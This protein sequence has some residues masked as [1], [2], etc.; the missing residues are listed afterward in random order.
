MD[1]AQIIN[2]PEL[3]QIVIIDDIGTASHHQLGFVD[4]Y[5]A[6]EEGICKVQINRADAMLTSAL[7]EAAQNP[8]DLQL[9]I[10]ILHRKGGSPFADHVAKT[11]RPP[12]AK[13]FHSTRF[14]QIVAIR[15]GEMNDKRFHIAIRFRPTRPVHITMSSVITAA[16]E[17]RKKH[18]DMDA[19][20]LMAHQFANMQL[21]HAERCIESYLN[22][23]EK[24]PAIPPITFS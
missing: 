5:M 9:L 19:Q 20:E 8:E 2:T 6:S 11:N 13:L 18:P 1:F 16:D 24:A 17:L 22:Y 21:E 23:A 3:G 14:G 4:V 12:F 7:E 10:Q 15:D